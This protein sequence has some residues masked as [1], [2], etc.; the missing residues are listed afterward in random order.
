MNITKAMCKMFDSF[1]N[2]GELYDVKELFAV[3][4]KRMAFFNKLLYFEEGNP[5]S[6]NY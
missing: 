2:F 6:I 4:C 1:L 3:S 5:L